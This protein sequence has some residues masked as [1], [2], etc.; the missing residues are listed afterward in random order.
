MSSCGVSGNR[1]NFDLGT[2]A[3]EAD[4]VTVLEQAAVQHHPATGGSLDLGESGPVNVNVQVKNVFPQPVAPRM[5]SFNGML[6]RK[7]EV[8]Q[9]RKEAAWLQNLDGSAHL[10]NQNKQQG[11]LIQ[12][13]KRQMAALSQQLQKAEETTKACEANQSGSGIPSAQPHAA[14]TSNH[15]ETLQTQK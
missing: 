6:A 13:C 5:N 8:W 2:S 10:K 7:R 14:M 11:Q 3:S 15:E 9:E 1:E 4:A 12:K